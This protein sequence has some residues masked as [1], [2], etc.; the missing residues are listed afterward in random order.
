MSNS[1]AAGA[2]VAVTIG[3]VK[4]LLIG[5]AMIGAGVVVLLQLVGDTTG[6]GAVTVALTVGSCF[7]WSVFVWVLFG[8]FE[9]TLSALVTIARN[10]GQQLPGSYDVPPTAYD[11]R[12]G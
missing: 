11:P 5:L 1:M 8:W 12:R 4:W 10:T 9:H 2:R 7:V 3:V 6:Y